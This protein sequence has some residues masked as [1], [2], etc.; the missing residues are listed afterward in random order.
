MPASVR[1]PYDT[2]EAF[3]GQHVECLQALLLSAIP[4]DRRSRDPFLKLHTGA[5][6][7]TDVASLCTTFV[8]GKRQRVNVT[9]RSNL[10][11]R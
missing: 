5:Y 11:C 2:H 8:H 3:P 10:M 1:G 9:K 7:T 4:D 6:L